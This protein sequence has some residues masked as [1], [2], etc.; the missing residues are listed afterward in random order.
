MSPG[1]ILAL[2]LVLDAFAGEPAWLYRR[3]RHPVVLMSDM[4]MAGEKHLNRMAWSAGHRKFAGSILI[5]LCV[6]LL[7]GIGTGL[8]Q[9]LSGSVAGDLVLVVLIFSL[10]AARSL[11]DHVQAVFQALQNKDG[12]TAARNAVG[13]I[14]GRE[15]TALDEA[16]IS[17]AS[18]ESLAENFSDG[19]AAPV[20]WYLLAGLPGLLVYKMVNTADSMIGHRSDRFR[21]FGWAAARLDDLL[22]LVPAR[23]T[24]LLFTAVAVLVGKPGAALV[25][26]WTQARNHTSPNAGWPEAAMAGALD[27]RLGGPRIYPGNQK[28]DGAWFGD[29]NEA[30]PRQIV[31]ALWLGF[32]SWLVILLGVAGWGSL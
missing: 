16:A 8:E 19:I 23:L 7:A 15:T 9:G 25:T 27:I 11:Y 22:N 4:L 28:V 21:D 20:F 18:I 32:F 5:S 3:L 30:G 12:L 26:A 24:A 6:L 10:L 17:R 14:I 2:A 1:L 31:K 29:G 13:R